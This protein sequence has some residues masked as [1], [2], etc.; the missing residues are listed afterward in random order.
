MASHLHGKICQ[1]IFSRKIIHTVT[2]QPS[3]K[4]KPGESHKVRSMREVQEVPEEEKIGRGD[5]SR[6]T[7]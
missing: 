5:A 1:N 7:G 4:W 2:V 3:N 6:K